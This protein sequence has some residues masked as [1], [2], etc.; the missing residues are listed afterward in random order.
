[1]SG[2]LSPWAD[3]S[4]RRHVQEHEE[5]KK[6]WKNKGKKTAARS[7]RSDVRRQRDNPRRTKRI[8]SM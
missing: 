8:T 4:A 7:G 5:A 6:D 1:M 2:R 3:F